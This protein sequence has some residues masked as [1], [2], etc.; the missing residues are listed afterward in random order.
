[1]RTRHKVFGTTPGQRMPPKPKYPIGKAGNYSAPVDTAGMDAVMKELLT[2][3]K[4]PSL[5]ERLFGK[6]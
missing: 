6:K 2:G 5:L 3:K 4:Q 1:M